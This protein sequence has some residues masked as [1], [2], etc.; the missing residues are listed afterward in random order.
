MF[1]VEMVGISDAI[2]RVFDSALARIGALIIDTLDPHHEGSLATTPLLMR[3]VASGLV[4]IAAAW[5]RSG[6]VEPLD[7]VAEAAL[8]L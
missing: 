5:V 8:R 4:G 1:L 7:E 3:G 2:D 6:H